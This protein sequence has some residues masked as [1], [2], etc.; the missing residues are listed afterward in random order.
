MINT[1]YIKDIMNSRGD[2]DMSYAGLVTRYL[3]D[4]MSEHQA[5]IL[6]EF[7]ISFT[8]WNILNMIVMNL[9]LNDSH[10]KRLDWLDFRNRIVSIIHGLFI[11]FL[12]AYN[13]FF[14]H[15]GC[16]E[17]NTR[18]EELLMTFTNGYFM[19]DLVAMAYLGI[20]DKSMTIHHAICIGGLSAGLW[21]GLSGDVLLGSIFVAEISN[22]SMHTR[23]MLRLL[24]FR[25][26]KAYEVAEWSYMILYI[27]GRTGLGLPV[28]YRTWMCDSNHVIVKL[29]GTGLVMQS[30][31]FMRQMVSILK[32]RINERGERKTKK[33]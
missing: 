33:V 24:G 17:S 19:Y 16:G 21:T 20:L 22:P 4:Y 31:F 26:T 29:M 28:L 7:F 27:F 13:T 23:N 15:S 12:S 14:V 30:L 10:L 6:I 8:L 32:S 3:T 11:L 5:Q 1:I 25:Y 9:K 2:S 18:F